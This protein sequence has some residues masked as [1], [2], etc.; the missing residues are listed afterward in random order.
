L[1][2]TLTGRSRKR[3]VTARYR[4]FATLDLSSG[5]REKQQDSP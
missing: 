3:L 4:S 1:T 2:A 5:G